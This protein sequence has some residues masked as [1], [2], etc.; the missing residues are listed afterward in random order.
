MTK[1]EALDY[2]S[3]IKSNIRE[4][5]KEIKKSKSLEDV[6]MSVF[7]DYISYIIEGALVLS[8]ALGLHTFIKVK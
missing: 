5:E 6:H 2:I 3:S 8:R 7:S 1:R 4:L